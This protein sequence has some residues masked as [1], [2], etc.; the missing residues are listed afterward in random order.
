[1]RKYLLTAALVAIGLP[2]S[3]AVARQMD[4]YV[5][6]TTMMRAGP[7]YDY[8]AVQR[9]RRDSEVTVYGCLRDWNWCDV[10][11]RY[12]RGWVPRQNIVVSYRGRRRYVGSSMGILILSF[13]FNNYWDSYYRDR[14][15]YSQRPRW[16]QHYNNNYRPSWGPRSTAPRVEPQQRQPGEGRRQGGRPQGQSGP[17]MRGNPGQQASPGNGNAGQSQAPGNRRGN[18]DGKSNNG[19]KSRD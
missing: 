10:S 6:R 5:V 4:G 18:S 2:L 7:D 17:E 1:M 9:L 14:P 19:R 15:F 16:E 13:S 8:P 11:N 12:E 3:P